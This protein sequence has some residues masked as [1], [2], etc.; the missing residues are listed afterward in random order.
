MFTLSERYK[1][2]EVIQI[3]VREWFQKSYGNTYHTIKVSLWNGDE[4]D[5][6]H[7][8]D[9]VAGGLGHWKHTAGMLLLSRGIIEADMDMSTEQAAY[10]AVNHL[11]IDDHKVKIHEN[12]NDVQRKKDLAFN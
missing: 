10:M 1:D 3:D 4:W 12:V 9:I 5:I 8:D 11:I 7:I 2:V 6:Y